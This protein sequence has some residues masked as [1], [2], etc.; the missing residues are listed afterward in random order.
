M[1]LCSPIPPQRG[2]GRI[3]RTAY[4]CGCLALLAC[5]E[6]PKTHESGSPTSENS[7]KK[8]SEKGCEQRSGRRFGRYA[9]AKTGR[10]APLRCPQRPSFEL[11]R[12]F[13]DSFNPKFTLASKAGGFS[14]Y[15]PD[16]CLLASRISASRLW[17]SSSP[18][19][20]VSPALRSSSV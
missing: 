2:A 3:L 4:L 1:Y 19:P 15:T 10:I 17:G 18:S 6:L 12:D 8:L 7:V 14:G 11:L 5:S 9:G 13:S 20:G 16:S